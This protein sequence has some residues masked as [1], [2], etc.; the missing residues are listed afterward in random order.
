MAINGKYTLEERKIVRKIRDLKKYQKYFEKKY[1]L[2]DVFINIAKRQ[3][4]G[5]YSD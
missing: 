1:R 4:K 2:Y 3:I 5:K